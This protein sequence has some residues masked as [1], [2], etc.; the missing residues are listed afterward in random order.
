[1]FN[2]KNPNGDGPVAPAN[3]AAPIAPPQMRKPAAIAPLPPKRKEPI[4]APT[5]PATPVQMVSA[6]APAPGGTTFIG[7]DI[8]ITGSLVSSGEV[9]IEG[10]IEGDVRAKKITVKNNANINGE[11]ASEE[12]IIHG[13]VSGLVRGVKILLAS[14]CILNGDILHETLSIES[15][16]QFEGSCKRSDDPLAEKKTQSKKSATIKP[17]AAVGEMAVEE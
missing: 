13:R 15:G 8:V 16:A 1:M 12:L 5:A 14:D 17:L 7:N 4:A 3:G 11:L 10:T 2:K 6:P 9:V